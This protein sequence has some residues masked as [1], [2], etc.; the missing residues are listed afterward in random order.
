MKLIGPTLMPILLLTLPLLYLE[1]NASSAESVQTQLDSTFSYLWDSELN[2]WVF[3]SSGESHV[4]T[5]YYYNEDGYLILVIPYH[6]SGSDSVEWLECSID[7]Y[8]YDED[9]NR[10]QKIEYTRDEQSGELVPIGRTDYTYN[11]N[12]ILDSYASYNVEESVW[13]GSGKLVYGYDN[14]GN[15]T[16]SIEYQWE[17]QWDQLRNGWSENRKFEY[18]YDDHNNMV[19]ETIFEWGENA[20]VDTGFKV[21][22]EYTYDGNG[23]MLSSEGYDWDQFEN[24]W[25][26]RDTRME[27]TYDENDRVVEETH[28]HWNYSWG[29]WEV[30][31]QIEYSYDEQG[32]EIQAL[33]GNGEMAFRKREYFYDAYGNHIVTLASNMDETGDWRPVT[34]SVLHYSLPQF[35]YIPDAAFLHALINEGVDMN[36]DSLISPAE[37]EAV[38]SLDV[39][40]SNSG[41]P[42]DIKDLSGI[43]A[44]INLDSLDCGWNKLTSLDVSNNTSLTALFCNGNE[45]SG[46][47]VSDNVALTILD[48]SDNELTSM[49]LTGHINLSEITI[50]G[51]PEL[52]SVCV[53]TA[54]FPPSGVV[55]HTDPDVSFTDCL[56]PV[57]TVLYDSL[58]QPDMLE[59]SSSEDGMIYLVSSGTE[60]ATAAIRQSSVDSVIALAGAPAELSLSGLEN[61]VYWLYALDLTGNISESE[62]I[63]IAGVGLEQHIDEQIRIYPNPARSYLTVETINSGLTNI[64]I[65]STDGHVLLNKESDGTGHRIDLSSLPGGIYFITIRS[66]ELLTTRKIIL[67]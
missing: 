38:I 39:T 2:D 50:Y 34:K 36:G 24:N 1:T 44:F 57:L 54:L 26:S 48:V 43:E 62:A 46:L 9:G 67:L 42:G 6:Y 47:D 41:S 61:G 31:N 3:D 33:R 49:D 7:G 56:E 22:Y 65:T 52:K 30:S 45:L 11:E 12:G 35:V 58:Y 37:A 20:W 17:Y 27:Y 40:G 32:R 19:L 4:K 21:K 14:S 16:Y 25:L 5:T 28:I 13:V 66:T 15:K 53:W 8:T 63:R 23:N 51:N 60:R 18:F 10:I 59:A 55:I 29:G 64:Q